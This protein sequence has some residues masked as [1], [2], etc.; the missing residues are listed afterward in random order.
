[1]LKNPPIQQ[2]TVPLQKVA[3]PVPV[4]TEKQKPQRIDAYVDQDNRHSSID[5]YYTRGRRFYSSR[6]F[7][8]SAFAIGILALIGLG[9]FIGLSLQKQNREAGKQETE[10]VYRV[11]DNENKNSSDGTHSKDNSILAGPTAPGALSLA[12]SAALKA[13]KKSKSA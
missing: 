7:L 4:V 8:V 11:S 5:I 6:S 10:R 12:D 9:V 1:T 13:N 3:E 2:P